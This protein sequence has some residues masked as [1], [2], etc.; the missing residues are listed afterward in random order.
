MNIERPK[1]RANKNVLLVALIIIVTC[2]VDWLTVSADLLREKY[3]TF[4]SPDGQFQIVVMRNKQFIG[5]LPG[6]TGDSRGEVRLY[7]KQGHLLNKADIEMVQ[8]VANVEWSEKFVR[9]KFVAD[10]E[11]PSE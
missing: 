1:R 2:C 4:D 5:L 6:Q 10:W 8:L 9:I 11:L 3:S 7:N